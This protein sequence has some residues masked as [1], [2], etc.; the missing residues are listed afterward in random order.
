[1]AIQVD[2]VSNIKLNSKLVRKFYAD[3]WSRKIALTDEK[4][5][6]WQFINS[7]NNEESDYCV[8]AYDDNKKEVLGVM[9][10]N[11]REF[12][13]CGKSYKGAEL[14]TWIVKTSVSGLGL[15][16]RILKFIQ[17]N[18]EVLIGMGISDIAIP[19]Y[20]KSG[21][22]YVKAIPR[23]VKVINFDV[24]ESY[25]QHTKL[26]EKL[27]EKWSILKPYE[28]YSKKVS[29]NE[30]DELFQKARKRINL[31]SRDN[32]HRIWRYEKHPYFQYRQYLIGKSKDKKSQ[33]V[34]V[35]FREESSLKDF[36]ILHI[37]DLFGEESLIPFA[38]AFIENYAKANR[39]DVIDFYCTASSIYRFMLNSGWFSINDDLCFQFPHLFHPIEMRTPPTTSLIYWSKNNLHEIADFSRLYITKQD[40]D[41]DRPTLKTIDRIIND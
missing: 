19:I 37:M 1:M 34:F 32:S 28:F 21:F 5:Y 30:Y 8:V 22:R 3:N 40:A 25:S 6:E 41:L 23:F 10:L 33:K 35:A 7:P 12:Y 17:E 39:F 31:F 14:T 27:I 36:K 15:G 2:F 20:M 11:K 18:F 16:S 38:I 4:F 26:A 13:L 24:I 9:G 29:I